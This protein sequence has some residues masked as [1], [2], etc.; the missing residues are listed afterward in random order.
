MA[1][2]KAV[3]LL[4]TLTVIAVASAV[5]I[6]AEE[7]QLDDAD[8]EDKFEGAR[9]DSSPPPSSAA[10]NDLIAPRPGGRCRIR[11]CGNIRVWSI[12]PYYYW[13]YGSQSKPGVLPDGGRIIGRCTRLP[14]SFGCYRC[15]A[16]KTTRCLKVLP[17]FTNWWF[18]FKNASGELKPVLKG[19]TDV[20]PVEK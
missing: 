16:R 7:I 1:I 2:R 10:P 15:V 20:T 13:W 12:C 3:V 5:A 8:I 9:K 19:P 4:L 18:C 17:R 6:A 14:W 11:W